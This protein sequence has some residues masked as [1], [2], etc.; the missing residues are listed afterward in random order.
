MTAGRVSDDAG[1]RSH[2]RDGDT[3]PVERVAATVGRLAALLTAGVPP[4]SAW[5]YLSEVAKNGDAG[6]VLPSVSHAAASGGNISAALAR[7]DNVR[8]DEERRAWHGLAAAWSVASVTGAPMAACLTDFARTLR[9]LGETQRDLETALAGPRATSRLVMALPIISV[10]F[11]AALG[12]NTVGTLFGTGPGIC[13]LVLG[14][15]LLTMGWKWSTRMVSSAK[16]ATL[17]PGLSIDLM[18][19][20]ITGGGS[21]MEAREGVV[22]AI[23]RFGITDPWAMGEIDAV[24]DLCRRAGVPAAELLR[25]EAELVRRRSRSRGQRAAA[26]LAVRLMIPLALCVLP[27]FMVLGVVPLM[28]TVISSTVTSF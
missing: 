5:Q 22:K 20:A 28:L 24:L 4:R 25:T 18:A 11:G 6:S 17:T 9:E 15:A 21:L 3:L 7:A 26:R 2:R 1:Q 10:L 27:A 13:C 14:A 8:D 19:I 16:P 23:D 12:F